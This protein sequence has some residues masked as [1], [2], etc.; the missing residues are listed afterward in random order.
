MTVSVQQ[1]LQRYRAQGRAVLEETPSDK[2]HEEVE[3]QGQIEKRLARILADPDGLKRLFEEQPQEEQVTPREYAPNE[4]AEEKTRKR[5]EA[6]RPL[7]EKYAQ[8]LGQDINTPDGQATV[9]RTVKF[10]SRNERQKEN[11]EKLVAK[12]E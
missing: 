5:A 8:I 2:V 12:L 6:I 10:Y 3:R 7:A 9:E 1:A 11:F 4:V